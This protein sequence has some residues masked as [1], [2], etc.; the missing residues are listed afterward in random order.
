MVIK[1]DLK[2]WADTPPGWQ[3][4]ILRELIGQGRLSASDP[5]QSA[6]EVAGGVVAQLNELAQRVT[7]VLIFDS[8][9]ALHQKKSF[10]T[11][12]ENHLVIPLV[13]DRGVRQI[14]SGRLPA[15]FYEFNVRTARTLHALSPLFPPECV[16]RLMIEQLQQASL[17]VGTSELEDGVRSAAAMA[18]GHPLLAEKLANHLGRAWPPQFDDAWSRET[19]EQ[20][21]KPFIDDF[22]L[23]DIDQPWKD[24]VWSISVLDSFDMSVL[25]RYLER[26]SS[27]LLRGRRED[28]VIQGLQALRL[29]YTLLWQAENGY[30][31]CGVIQDIIRHCLHVLDADR[32]RDACE[33]AAATFEELAS[34]FLDG[35]E[36]GRRYQTEAD[37]YRRRTK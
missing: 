14:F 11:W 19:C 24:I 27:D 4:A 6:E 20:V 12:L 33:S 29:Q 23:A 2:P 35:D 31:L 26:F 13:V 30:R 17:S 1:V 15:P 21:L 36:E 32:Y 37:D 18:F 16:Q 25:Q 28:F 5:G 3:K 22:L 8:T 10:W 7:I 34:L 9:D